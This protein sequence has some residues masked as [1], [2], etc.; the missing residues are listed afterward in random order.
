MK[1]HMFGHPLFLIKGALMY[2]LGFSLTCFIGFIA[3]VWSAKNTIPTFPPEGDSLPHTRTHLS[4]VCSLLSFFSQSGVLI[5][6]WFQLWFYQIQKLS[7]K[8]WCV[9]LKTYRSSFYSYC[10]EAGTSTSICNQNE[11]NFLYIYWCF[12]GKTVWNNIFKI[13]RMKCR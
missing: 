13:L 12:Y 9:E 7:L 11:L 6:Y 1:P 2:F 8:D 5:N 4:L 3:C 10:Q